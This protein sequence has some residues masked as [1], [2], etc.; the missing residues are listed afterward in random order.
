VRSAR[1]SQLSGNRFTSNNRVVVGC[2]KCMIIVCIYNEYPV[3]AESRTPH[4]AFTTRVDPVSAPPAF[5]PRLKSKY[6]WSCRVLPPG[7]RTLI[8]QPRVAS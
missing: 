5:T 8:P 4:E 7:P 1:F 3:T 2:Y 6:W